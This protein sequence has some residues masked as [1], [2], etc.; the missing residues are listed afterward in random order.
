LKIAGKIRGQT[1]QRPPDQ[2]G[3]EQQSP[4]VTSD[5]GRITCADGPF[6]EMPPISSPSTRDK[7]QAVLADDPG[8]EGMNLSR[9]GD[10][11]QRETNG[12]SADKMINVAFEAEGTPVSD[13]LKTEHA[14]S[15][16]S[17]AGHPGD[18]MDPPGRAEHSKITLQDVQFHGEEGA[19]PLQSRHTSIEKTERF[20]KQKGPLKRRYPPELSEKAEPTESADPL[21]CPVSK[22]GANTNK[23]QLKGLSAKG[24]TLR[25]S[26]PSPEDAE[27]STVPDH[28]VIS[29]PKDMEH[30]VLREFVNHLEITDQVQ[31][32]VLRDLGIGLLVMPFLFAN[33][34]GAGQW[35]F[36]R[37]NEDGRQGPADKQEDYHITF[38][39]FLRRLGQIEIHLFKYGKK[40][41]LLLSA[42][43]DVLPVIR[44]GLFELNSRIKTIGF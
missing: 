26:L 32:Q 10:T 7:E 8:Q 41:N 35:I 39:L 20:L 19:I 6:S 15:V 4:I 38:D 2:K 23:V 27:A 31:Q 42:R 22:R 40:L 30:F 1:G 13:A 44:G 9:G 34:E 12:S 43:R 21:S 29:S 18:H 5:K 3:I 14:R 24:D 36:W 16:R 25:R 33:V 11:M 37:E 28:T 17:I